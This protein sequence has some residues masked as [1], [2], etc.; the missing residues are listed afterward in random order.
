MTK[1]EF[2]TMFE[3]EMAELQ[4]QVTA[5]DDRISEHESKRQKT[6]EDVRII[7]EATRERG[8]LRRKWNSLNRMVGL[9]AYAR[10]KAMTPEELE[11]YNQE[12]IAEFQPRIDEIAA[13]EREARELK[14]VLEARLRESITKSVTAETPEAKRE[15]LRDRDYFQSELNTCYDEK[16]GY[17]FQEIARDRASLQF[18][19]DA[20]AARTPEEIRQSLAEKTRN[21][22]YYENLLTNGV[23][24]L[25]G[26]EMLAQ[27]AND[28]EKADKMARMV[29]NYGAQR[30]LMMQSPVRTR[31]SVSN[32][33]QLPK[34]LRDL[35]ALHTDR[36][37]DGY[38]HTVEDTTSLE[39]V[40]RDYERRFKEAKNALLYEELTPEK[41]SFLVGHEYIGYDN[42][43]KR[44]PTLK[45]ISQH[46]SKIQTP[47]EY[48]RL[49]HLTERRD[50]LAKKIIKTSGV[51]SE[52]AICNMQIERSSDEICCEI[53][54][55]YKNKYTSL[56]GIKNGL[57]FSSAESLQ[58]SLGAVG[59][60]IAHSEEAISELKENVAKARS[61]LQAEKLH[62]QEVLDQ[63]RENIVSYA[64]EEY[65]DV[66][67]YTGKEKGNV[68][69]YAPSTYVDAMR[70][71][72]SSAQTVYEKDK[73]NEVR[74]AVNE[75]FQ[76]KESAN[77]PVSLTEETPAV[78]TPIVEE[79]DEYQMPAMA[80][81]PAVNFNAVVM[82]EPETIPAIK[83]D[84]YEE[85]QMAPVTPV[86]PAPI[87]APAYEPVSTPAPAPTTM[88]AVQ[89]TDPVDTL[90]SPAATPVQAQTNELET[91]V[92]ETV[93]NEPVKGETYVKRD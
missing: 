51:K 86:A 64:G 26:A 50:K 49:K 19:I 20:I 43:N 88:P 47:L 33:Y 55:W 52:L 41:I 44:V 75:V 81:A 13:R 76:P 87:E 3:R 38:T 83:F 71:I 78:T 32:P 60:D 2:L 79:K 59:R 39:M 68:D 74:E 8:L 27:V 66:R 61:Q 53:I 22:A 89:Y 82:P 29:A 28:P 17:V 18:E 37:K 21:P 6:E 5:L 15:A 45:E 70:V 9:P 56:L 80:S 25:K 16:T 77:I 36:Q 14:T 7:A 63:L 48:E 30:D 69:F 67:F 91:M 31:L 92:T 11:A 85:E 24:V 73:V 40:V 93:S 35:V 72:E 23:D 65:K 4:D 1:E 57:D 62:R 12:K 34:D 54:N 42:G 10:I 84:T 58:E 46:E 90:Y